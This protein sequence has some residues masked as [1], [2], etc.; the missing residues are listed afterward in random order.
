MSW[1][2]ER[3]EYL[4]SCKAF[5]RQD[6]VKKRSHVVFTAQPLPA[7]ADRSDM[8]QMQYFLYE[9]ETRLLTE[10]AVMLH[11]QVQWVF[12]LSLSGPEKPLLIV[13]VKRTKKDPSLQMNSWLL[14][15]QSTPKFSSTYWICLLNDCFLLSFMAALA[16]VVVRWKNHIWV[17]WNREAT[18]C[19]A[20]KYSYFF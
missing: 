18:P 15:I 2:T 6:F 16:A 19:P 5:P 12:P 1:A 8:D 13:V 9:Q 20:P 17:Q 14:F 10:E 3:T 7:N 4:F 11:P